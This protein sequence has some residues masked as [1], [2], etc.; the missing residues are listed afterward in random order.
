VVLSS[1]AE[2]AK[3]EYAFDPAIGRLGDPFAPPVRRF[4]LLGLQL[5]NHGR[6]VR[7]L[8]GVGLGA[9][10]ALA[11]Q[12]HHPPCLSQPHFRGFFS[13]RTPSLAPWR[14]ELV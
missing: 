8:P 6:R 4:A 13:L 3:P 9:A 7:I 2:L 12:G 5:A 1:Q 14:A 10:L 11:S